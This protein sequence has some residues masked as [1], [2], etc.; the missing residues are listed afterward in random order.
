MADVTLVEG[1]LSFEFVGVDFAEK[2]D[3]WRH[4]R[5][6]FNSAC[7]SSKAVDFIVSKDNELW[8]IEVKDFR[9]NR[10]TKP[11]DLA[12]EIALKVRDTMAGLVS[13]KFVGA[14]PGEVTASASALSK[15]KLRVALHLEQPRNPSRLFPISVNPAN[16]KMKLRQNLKFADAH[17]VVVDLAGFPAHLGRV[18]S[19]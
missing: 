14:N 19:I 13:T 7:G 12:D 11:I 6:K 4:Y 9:R 1:R 5:N 8:L 16:I 2:Y 3:E 15:G 17:P 10:R 18:V